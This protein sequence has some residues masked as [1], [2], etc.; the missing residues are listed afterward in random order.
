[1]NNK[2]KINLSGARFNNFK[3]VFKSLEKCLNEV[4]IDFYVLG[5]LARDMLFSNEE[6]NTRTTAD[7]DLA[8]YINTSDED[9]YQLL[10]N[11]LIDDYDFEESKE[12]N[13]A[14]ISTDGT[15]IDLLPFGE[16]EVEDGVTFMGDGLSNIKVNGFKE[17]HLHGL[18]VV[19]SDELATFKVAKLSS[20]I[21]LKLI[22][23]DDRPEMRA[24]DPGDTASIIANY[25]IINDEYIYDNHNDL[26][27]G[28]EIELEFIAAQVIGREMKL[29]IHENVKLKERV[30][31][32]LESHILK[33]EKSRFIVGMIG[34]YCKQV[35][36][37]V[38]WLNKIL[39]GIKER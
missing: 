25:F 2:L 18:D 17:V 6:I 35:D 20:I 28:D 32:I 19:E 27:E 29:T 21:L 12:N 30:K 38:L 9:V 8:V 26:F 5:A 39:Q 15:I 34:D 23:F 16:I 7:V 11:K 4:G 31:I 22:A 33:A 36:T 10:R 3:S 13:F 24:N 1:M 37:A 14:L